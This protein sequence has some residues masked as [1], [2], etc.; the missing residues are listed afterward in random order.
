MR[1]VVFKLTEHTLGLSLEWVRE[2]L[3]SPSVTAIPQSPDFIEGVIYLRKHHVAAMNL[4][5]RLGYPSL[6]KSQDYY[7]I[8][9]K[10]G[11]RV[12]GL[13]VDKI[14][15]IVEIDEH[16]IDESRKVG[17]GYVDTRTLRGIC[18]K[19]GKEIFLLSLENLLREKVTSVQP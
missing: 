4:R 8:M 2:I 5:K 18:L 19:E 9:V 11:N 13:I 15:S 17:P 7:V 1:Y 12:L 6:E 3:K 10:W 14:L 16:E